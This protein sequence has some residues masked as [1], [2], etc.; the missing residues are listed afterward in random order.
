MAYSLSVI[1][2]CFNNP[3]ELKFTCKSVEQQS[4][5]PDEHLIIDGSTNKAI[6]EYLELNP[7]PAFRKWI[8][9]RDKNHSDAFNKG[10]KNATGEIIHL[11]N[12]GDSYYDHK[13]IEMVMEH[14]E[15]NPSIQWIHGK[16][17]QKQGGI[18]VISGKPFDPGKL[19]R[20]MRTVAHP[21]M[22]VK[23]AVYERIGYFDLN[24]EVAMDYDFLVRIR[25]EPFLFID[26][27]M[28][29]FEPGGNSALRFSE[30]LAECKES[31]R[32]YVGN[33]FFMDLWF[34]RTR[35]I[36]YLLRHRAG[37]WLFRIK[38]KLTG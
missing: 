9:E 5:K 36:Q 28:A 14:F 4:R 32:K 17:Q 13:V 35:I 38:N 16:Y 8:C 34:I 10:V 37:K 27:P 23:K 19:Y 25:N 15:E 6:K 29:K 21:T 22:F 7:Q 26:Q 3:E 20:G 1:T 33:T 31:Y 2:I 30:G 12:S 11:L 24:K 18:R